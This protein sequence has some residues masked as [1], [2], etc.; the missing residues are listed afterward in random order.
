[1]MRS[2]GIVIMLILIATPGWA[3]TYYISSSTGSDANTSTQAQSSST[4]WANVRGM[5]CAT[6]NA[7]S[8]TPVAG[9][10]F[11]FRGGDTWGNSCFEWIWSWSGTSGARIYLGVD[12]TWYAGGAWTLPILD[13]QGSDVSGGNNR[14]LRFNS[15]YVTFDNFELTGMRWISGAPFGGSAFINAGTSQYLFIENNYLHGWTNNVSTEDVG[16]GIMSTS[17]NPSL[18]V[19]ME[20]RYNVFDGSDTAA[21]LADPNCTGACQGSLNALWYGPIVHHN[22]IR[23]VSNGYIGAAQQFN[24]NL[25]EY[26]RDSTSAGV[27]ENAFEN[28]ADPCATG[29]IFYNNV[30]RH[31]KAG[32]TVWPDPD[33]PG[34]TPS[35]A[36]NNVIYDTTAGN[37]WNIGTPTTGTIHIYNNTVQCGPESTPT[38][39]CISYTNGSDGTV[40]NTHLMTSNATPIGGGPTEIT[41]IIHTMATANGQG[42]SSGGTY[43]YAPPAGG[44]TIGAG[45]NLT[46]SCTG[47]LATLCQDTTFACSYDSANHLPICPARTPQQRPSSGAWDAGAYQ[48]VGGNHRPPVS[49]RPPVLSH[50]TVPSR[51][52]APS[53]PGL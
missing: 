7:A 50:P 37:V 31:I 4:P 22:I 32:V 25:I 30:I 11:I 29:L 43:G 28:N 15:G 14:M 44:S 18:N 9:D 52:V 47:N 46:A 24:D 40:E 34:C 48:F 21:V 27:H 10:R 39:Q 12:K 8:Y 36:W 1:M 35:Y 13:A 53:R 23:Y 51:P 5:L 33:S 45:T 19:G 38:Y 17:Q 20:I 6:G 16:S 2:L 49:S 42:Y 41:N 3:A 26:I